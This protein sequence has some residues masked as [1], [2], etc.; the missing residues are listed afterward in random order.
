M[1]LCFYSEGNSLIYAV[2][3][4]FVLTCSP[5]SQ[6]VLVSI[7]KLPWQSQRISP[8]ELF[9]SALEIRHSTFAHYDPVVL[10]MWDVL[11]A[12]IVGLRIAEVVGSA[13]MYENLIQHEIEIL[14]ILLFDRCVTKSS[15]SSLSLDKTNALVPMETLEP[16]AQLDMLSPL[17]KL[18]HSALVTYI[19]ANTRTDISI[20]RR[21][22]LTDLLQH[23][24]DNVGELTFFGSNAQNA[25]ILL[26]GLMSC[27]LPAFNVNIKHSRTKMDLHGVLQICG[28]VANLIVGLGNQS[29]FDTVREHQSGIAKQL[30][31]KL[32]ERRKLKPIDVDA[33]VIA[34]VPV[35]GS[36]TNAAVR[37]CMMFEALAKTDSRFDSVRAAVRMACFKK[38]EFI[39]GLLE[40]HELDPDVERLYIDLIAWSTNK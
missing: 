16:Q 18:L 6:L 26:S 28:N 24:H 2:S 9:R 11:Q 7:Q 31:K 13:S 10:D 22:A 23:V 30:H 14:E 29:M 17:E 25:P 15:S 12:V 38:D 19:A 34:P 32:S 5:F 1:G 3:P 8:H 20:L 27:S 4:A 36:S 21:E 40:L 39:S 35:V 37:M 33:P